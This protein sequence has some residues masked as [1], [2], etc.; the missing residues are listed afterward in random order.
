MCKII[1]LFLILKPG[2]STKEIVTEFSGRGVGLDV[3]KRNIEEL[4]G[5]IKLSSFLGKG[6]T[7]ELKIK[8]S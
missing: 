8:K 6:T 2:F 7:F 4:G 3:V 5:D 1:G